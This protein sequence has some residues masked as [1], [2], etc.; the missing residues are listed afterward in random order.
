MKEFTILISDRNK[1]VREYIRREMVSEG[2]RV[3]V[4]RSARDI[5]ELVYYTESIDLLILDPDLFETEEIGL[6]EKIINRVPSLPVVVHAYSPDGIRQAEDFGSVHF[7]E[8]G[9]NSIEH[10][11]TAVAHLLNQ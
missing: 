7:V 11:K 5:L 2:Y 3:Q 6:L 4:A 8:K 1:N 9:G 10:L